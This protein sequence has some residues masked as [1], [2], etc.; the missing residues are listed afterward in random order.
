MMPSK[1]I[2]KKV[3][4]S[5]GPALSEKTPV[6]E[7]PNEVPRGFVIVEKGITKNLGDYN[8][9]KVTVSIQIPLGATAKDIADSKT[10]L[11]IAHEIVDN[12]LAKQVKELPTKD[13]L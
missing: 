7:V 12:E 1:I 5:E 3:A 2:K 13:D 9:A 6:K 4:P 8:S 10:A 11:A